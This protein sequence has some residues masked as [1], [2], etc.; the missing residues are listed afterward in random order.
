MKPS[1]DHI[2]V[3]GSAILLFLAAMPGPGV[4]QVSEAKTQVVPVWR[5]WS[6]QHGDHFY[7]AGEAERE[8]L[9]AQYSDVWVY[10]KVAFRAVAAPSEPNLAPVYRLWSES[11]RRHWYTLD[12]DQRDALMAGDDDLWIY[13]GVAFYVYPP[14]CEPAGTTAVHRY[15]AEPWTDSLYTASQKERFTLASL[16]P[17]LWQHQG[18]AWYAY[19]AEESL[20]VTI[21]KGPYLQSVTQDSVTVMWET[22]LPA[23]SGVQYDIGGATPA[24]AFDPAPVKLH[25]MAITDI[26]PNTVGTYQVMSGQTAS[27]VGSFATAPAFDRS[28]RFA[29]YGDTRVYTG[30]HAEVGQSI[31]DSGPELVFHVGDLVHA[32]RDYHGWGPEFF[33]PLKP[34]MQNIPLVPI[35]GNHEY[36]GDGPLWFFH[37]F[38][39]PLN[40]GWFAMTYGGVRFVGLDTNAAFDPTSVQYQ[41]FLEELSSSAYLDA[42]WHVVLYHHPTFTATERYADDPEVI[43]YLVPLLE[44]HDV[45]IVFQGHSH[46]YERYFHNGIYYIVTGGGSGPLYTLVEDTEPPI[47]QFGLTV[48]HHCSVDINTA[49][50]TLTLRAVDLDGQTFDTLE[51]QKGP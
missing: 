16:Y 1:T 13:E 2:R 37:F 19:P 11:L 31:I 38:D 39:R 15:W 27:N 22:D 50:K 8:K 25:K 20:D 14:G 24:L 18:V 43:S 26:E 41:W 49:E 33:N 3:L 30:V 23:D 48:N 40:E 44:A 17:D 45:D 7:T 35:L 5:F 29:V 9:I 21:V 4:G 10:E 34:L 32:G 28:F 47:R 42:T 36:Y 12:P 46:T 51:I 6:P